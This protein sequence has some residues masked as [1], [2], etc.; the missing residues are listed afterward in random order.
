MSISSPSTPF[1]QLSQK[2]VQFEVRLGPEDG[3]EP[4]IEHIAR[5]LYPEM[6]SQMAGSRRDDVLIIHTKTPGAIMDAGLE[7]YMNRRVQVWAVYPGEFSVTRTL[8]TWGVICRKPVL[9]DDRSDKYAFE[10]RIADEHFGERLEKIPTWDP[11]VSQRLDVMRPLVFNPEIDGLIEPNMSEQIDVDDGWPYVIDPES[12][13]TAAS[14]TLQIFEASRWHLSDAVLLLC[15]LLNPD[16]TFIKNPLSEDLDAAFGAR[17]ELLMNV[18]IPIGTSLPAALDM[19]LIPL[20]YSW[21]LSHSTDEEGLRRTTISFIQR[22]TGPGRQL[23][24]QRPGET[25]DIRQTNVLAFDALVSIADLANRVIC[26]GAYERREVTLQLYKA[27]D[28][29]YDTKRLADLHNNSPFAKEH[30]EVGRKFVLNEA[31]DYN[32]LR[33]EITSPFLLEGVFTEDPLMIV[34][35]KFFRCLSQHMADDDEES[36]GYYVEWWNQHR[37]GATLYSNKNDPGWVRVKWPFSVLEKEAGIVF[38]GDTPPPQLWSLIYGGQADGCHVRITATLVGDNR[39]KGDAVRQ[40]S[41]P[42]KLD[43]TLTLDVADKFQDSQVDDSEA[44]GSIFAASPTDA[45]DDTVAI[46]DYAEQVRDIEDALR[47]DTSIPLEG[48]LHPEYE[49]GNILGQIGG[50]AVSLKLAESRYP[51]IVGIVHHFQRQQVELLLESF[52]KERPR[53]VLENQNRVVVGPKPNVKK[54]HPRKKV[55]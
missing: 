28:P 42:N 36:N 24:M 22:G 40:S 8:I 20:E 45:R 11:I 50:R 43:M 48:A 23:L 44:F 25:R 34:R 12:M 17:D 33:P 4:T 54:L 41:S 51:Q 15:W 53:V 13:R 31:G 35:R 52:R 19:L 1:Q 10:A 18:G 16:E 2:A 55:F 46:Q 5:D 49:I 30:P 3:S 27:W 32:D 6:A 37:Q 26:Y 39:V 47:L 29:Q 14:Q 38:D 21:H 7:G 9:I